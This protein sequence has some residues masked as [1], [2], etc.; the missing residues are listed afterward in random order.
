MFNNKILRN[1]LTPLL[2]LLFFLLISITAIRDKTNTAD[3]ANHLVRGIMLLKTG[4]FRLNQHHP[5]LFNAL[6]AIPAVLNENLVT[7]PTDST[8]W[9]QARKDDMAAKLVELNGGSTVF[10]KNIL[11]ESRVSMAVLTGLF[12]VLFYLLIKKEFGYAA[13]TIATTLLLL[14]PTVLAHG[15]LVT[16]DVP[17]MFMIFFATWALYGYFKNPDDKRLNIFILVSFLALLTKFTALFTAFIW[18]CALILFYRQ[19]SGKFF[20]NAMLNIPRILI[21]WALL[22]WASHGF[23]FKSFHEVE[24]GN[25][26]LNKA[27]IDHISHISDTFPV[28][29]E[30][31]VTNLYYNLKLPFPQYIKGFYDNVFKHNFYG[32]ETFLLGEFSNKGWWYYFPVLFLAKENILFIA[33]TI[34]L[35]ICGLPSL[36][37]LFR[38]RKYDFSP[39]IVLVVVPVFLAI[40][41]L[42]SSINLGI[43]HL[44]PL[45]PFI[46]VLIAIKVMPYL[47][48]SKVIL[49]SFT[50]AIIM[51]VVSVLYQYPNFVEYYNEFFGGPR[52]GYMI[53]RDSNFD[54]GQNNGLA[55]RYSHKNANTVLDISQARTGDFLVVKIESLLYPA[56]RIDDGLDGL[57]EE[58]EKGEKHPIK[59]VTPTH[60]LFQID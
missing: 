15:A 51:M 11:F 37:R 24:Y 52:N 27:T 41:T 6:N 48:S 38:R 21:I 5:F 56:G 28:F 50:A 18:I 29:V 8:N 20:S 14:S 49:Y 30:D 19:R 4:D 1:I 57:R 58:Y 34:F 55:E 12:L 26:E 13:S 16:T 31:T 53:S 40:L 46:A 39:S 25:P 42:Q 22:L 32:H 44:L 17:A 54:W 47:R 3:E 23:Q 9:I 7:E 43:R 33:L 60:W 2:L 59:W 36:W 10:S 35:L 45:Y